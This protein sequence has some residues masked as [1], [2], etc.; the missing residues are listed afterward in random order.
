MIKAYPKSFHRRTWKTVPLPTRELPPRQRSIDKRIACP[1][2]SFNMHPLIPDGGQTL[3]YSVV[4]NHDIQLDYYLPPNATGTLPAVI[5]YHGGG[6]TAGSRR[7]FQFPR[8]I[9][10]KSATA[11]LEK[12]S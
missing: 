6:M 7:D 11:L 4:D 1:P 8:W 10:G 3:V 12:S 9:Y 5:Y 2:Y